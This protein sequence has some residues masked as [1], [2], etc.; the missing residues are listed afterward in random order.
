[1]TTARNGTNKIQE[2]V[3]I[4]RFTSTSTHPSVREAARRA[5]N[6]PSRRQTRLTRCA[7][8]CGLA[9]CCCGC[10][11]QRRKFSGGQSCD[12]AGIAHQ[13]QL[14]ALVAQG[15]GERGRV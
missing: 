13:W 2:C 3:E 1:M 8:V 9:W 15:Y 12:T 6:R 14:L 10:A 4:P 7:R 11:G 5:T